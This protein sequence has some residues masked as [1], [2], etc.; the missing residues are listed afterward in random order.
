MIREKVVL[1]SATRLIV[2]LFLVP[3][4]AANAL[5]RMLV[6]VPL[7]SLAADAQADP[8][9]ASDEEKETPLD[10]LLRAGS[11]GADK[12]FVAL[13]G[14]APAGLRKLLASLQ[15]QSLRGGQ[16]YAHEDGRASLVWRFDG[17]APGTDEEVAAR[18]R[19]ALKAGGFAG[20]GEDKTTYT[21][22][23]GGATHDVVV[24]SRGP[25]RPGGSDMIQDLRL[26][27]TIADT[28]PSP[29][30][31]LGELLKAVPVLKN[32]RLGTSFYETLAELPVSRLAIDGAPAR[33]DMWDATF[34][35]GSAT[36][37]AALEARIAKLLAGLGY[38]PFE[39]IP[40]KDE[41]VFQH[42]ST[43]IFA[44]LHRPDSKN[45]VELRFSQL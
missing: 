25:S 8:I 17:G 4:A 36:K 32:D 5:A 24:V 14:H 31:A 39:L 6:V 28:I 30:P 38:K 2:A 7:A 42:P 20:P 1:K 15:L 37:A 3:L 33:Y 16:V 45:R 10:R 29:E 23:K 11:V 26:R 40:V 18:T 41:R 9:A 12:A 21:L 13:P 43:N 35:A 19:A 27:W 22:A 34:T 44:Y